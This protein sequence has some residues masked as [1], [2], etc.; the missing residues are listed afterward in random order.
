MLKT[1]PRTGPDQDD[2]NH[3]STTEDNAEAAQL[4]RKL[5]LKGIRA[6]DIR[7]VKGTERDDMIAALQALADGEER[8]RWKRRT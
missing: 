7:I 2:P 4:F 5:N 8:A 1:A 6:P 3:R